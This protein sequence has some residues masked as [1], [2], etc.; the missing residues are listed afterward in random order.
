MSTPASTKSK[1]FLFKSPE[2]VDQENAK[3]KEENEEQDD[4]DAGPGLNTFEI[5]ITSKISR[6]PTEI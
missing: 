6:V 1:P 4:G 5:T 3:L 2:Q